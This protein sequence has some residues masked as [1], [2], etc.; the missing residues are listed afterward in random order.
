MT[1]LEFT[2]RQNETEQLTVHVIW[3]T[4][5]LGCDGDTVAM[6]AATQ[7]SLEDLLTR[8]LPGMPGVA[9]YNPFLAVENGDDFMQAWY[10]AEAGQAGPVH[11]RARGRG[12]ERAD[13]RRRALGRARHRPGQPA[14]RSPPTSGSTG[15]RR[16]RRS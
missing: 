12:A 9:L 13:Q 11:P 3:M 8:S 4:S 5:G 16:A 6:T 15:W 1:G 7:P 14:S 10:D 2:A